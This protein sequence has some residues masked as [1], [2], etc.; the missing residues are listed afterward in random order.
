MGGFAGNNIYRHAKALLIFFTLA[1]FLVD[2]F[3]DEQFPTPRSFL[4][5]LPIFP[6]VTREL[7]S[8]FQ[9]GGFNVCFTTQLGNRRKWA[10]KTC[11][12][13]TALRF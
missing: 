2:S 7:S 11:G 5:F 10:E 3:Y 13:L 1:Q 9:F 12:I 4:D 8:Q 6:V